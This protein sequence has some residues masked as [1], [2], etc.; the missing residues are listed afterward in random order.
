MSAPIQAL[1]FFL[2]ARLSRRIVL[3]VFASILL[4]EAII[5]LP[6]IYR[7]QQELLNNLSALS[8][9]RVEGALAAMRLSQPMQLG[10]P[11]FLAQIRLLAPSDVVRGGALYRLT[12][13]Q[14]DSFGEP[15]QL[16][17]EQAQRQTAMRYDWQTR[18]YDAAWTL[19]ALDGQYVLI[20][21]H[22]SSSVQRELLAFVGRIMGLVMIISVFVT[23]VTLIG[24]E[25]IL[26]MPILLLRNDLLKAGQAL[27]QEGDP[28]PPQFDSLKRQ[29]QDELGEVIAA[30]EQMY[31]Q[32]SEA[33]AERRQVESELRQSEEKFSKAFRGS[34]S[35]VLISA[36]ES[37]RIIEVNDSFLQLYGS[38]L[39]AVVGRTAKDLNLWATATSRDQM[40]QQ[41]RQSG[42]VRN[43]EYTFRNRQGEPRSIL[44][45]AET[46][47]LDGEECLVSVANDITERKQAEKALERLAEIGELAAMI[48][49]EVRNPLTTVMMGL[50]SFESLDLSER[51]RLRLDLATA[52]AERLQRLLNEILQYARCQALQASELEINALIAEMLESLQAMPAAAGR[53]IAFTPIQ[54]V[55][56]L[57][58]R[59]KLKQVLIN[60]IGNA[61]EAVSV[62]ETITW[63]LKL[64][65]ALRQLCIEIQNGGEPIPAEVLAQLTMPFFTTKSSG[66]GLGLAIVK[67]I[68]DAHKGQLEIHSSAEIGGTCVR[69]I[70]PCLA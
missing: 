11:D 18:R 34:P 10:S 29:S 25:R 41:I 32:I 61:C 48:V 28:P 40:L 26:I 1:R 13:E 21:R 3:W 57:A 16:T 46:I 15:P 55:R 6:S 66:N 43:L 42:S 20:I 53:Q 35:A 67:Q 49:H 69:V 36:L 2:Q 8:M 33:I 31:H 4:I 44:F 22:D 68:V 5:L 39:D 7:R 56:L 70:L 27:P 50:R 65:A 59:D 9:A 38:D 30:F 24:L 23:I 17:F 51:S 63:R 19:K 45:S 54:P 64:D 62:G 58:D 12:G 60:L 52:E 47:W 37:G 14:M